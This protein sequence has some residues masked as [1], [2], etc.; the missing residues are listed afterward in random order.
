MLPN[1]R[2]IYLIRFFS[3]FCQAIFFPFFA[4]WLL[5]E[6]LFY[7]T[8]AALIVSVGIFS[9]R[10]A[11]L[12]FNRLIQ[13]WDKKYLIMSSLLLLS[14]LYGLLYELATYH[15][16]NLMWWMLVSIFIG[17][18]L[19]I[20][21]LAILSYIA[22]QHT[23]QHHHVGF[24][25]INI[26]LNLSSGLGP[27][28]GS[29]I[30]MYQQRFFPLMPI[31]FAFITIVIS[32]WLTQEN[33]SQTETQEANFISCG[34]KNYIYFMVVNALTFIAYAQFYD[35][36]PAYA[37]TWLPEANIGMLFVVS[38]IVIVCTQLPLSRY[39]KK[40]TT[41]EALLFA[42]ILLA[43]G[44]VFLVPIATN[45]YGIYIIGVVLLS[46][47]EVIY[48]PLY[49]S[50]ALQLY[51]PTNH[52]VSLGMQSFVWGI[53]EATATFIG[54]YYIGHGAGYLS[55]ILGVIA[56]LLVSCYYLLHQYTPAS[57]HTLNF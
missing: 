15:I 5:K 53:A 54:I 1:T 10:L 29:I 34:G 44:T 7:A 21:S 36:F 22:A 17:S 52:I 9:T 51:Q 2:N 31:I 6:K 40:I 46:L 30:L 14:G 45:Y 49:Q 32:C 27:F 35:V 41:Q 28:L 43:I 8:Q 3:N 48:V 39:I 38:S 33:I 26:A 19:S 11:A 42:N 24:S 37:A 56:A 55:M 57:S 16:V 12:F 18:M 13:R 50:L 23:T 25:I 47:A 4:V 20:N